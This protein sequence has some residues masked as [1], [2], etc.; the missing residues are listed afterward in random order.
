MAGVCQLE[1]VETIDELRKLLRVQ[2]TASDKERRQLLY[3]LKSEQVK[4][5]A[6]AANLL[7]RHR[8][9]L[10]KWLNRY[11]KG[12][13]EN[14]LAHKPGTGRKQSIPKWAQKVLEKQLQQEQGFQSY[15]EIC[16]WLSSQLGIESNYQTVHKLVRYR[17]QAAPKVPRPES[18]KTSEAKAEVFKKK[19]AENLALLS[20]YALAVLGMS[21]QVRFFCED[22]TPIG[23]KTISGRK[24]TAR[25]V[26]PKGKV[27]WQFKATYLYG[28]VE[29][30]TGEHFFYE[31]SHL[32]S[33]CFQVFLNLI[34][35]H[36]ADSILPKAIRPSRMPSSQKIKDTIQHH[37]LVS[38]ISF[39]RNQSD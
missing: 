24:I 25:G 16:Q 7:G 1:I 4:T 35:Q 31:F 2:K 11:R 34:S 26:K 39:S 17:L 37:L 8:V 13:I 15:S 38:T 23:L 12:G 29:P 22:E 32:N 14:L 21:G 9:T 10:Q 30:K 36:F 19:R 6:M 33:D 27:Q 28:I 18:N 20:W 5:I 3:L